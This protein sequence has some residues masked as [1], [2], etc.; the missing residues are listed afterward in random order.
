MLLRTVHYLPERDERIVLVMDLDHELEPDQVQNVRNAFH[1]LGRE[2]IELIIVR[3]LF[4]V[5]P[6]GDCV[7]SMDALQDFE[8]EI[9]HLG[10]ATNVMI[11]RTDDHYQNYNVVTLYYTLIRL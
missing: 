5:D 6:N 2:E 9:M 4:D 11:F 1:D 7:Y 10:R 8:R 3:S